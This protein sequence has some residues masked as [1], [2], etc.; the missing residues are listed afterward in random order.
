V[1]VP[2][3]KEKETQMKV[4][5]NL[6]GSRRK[7]LG[8]AQVAILAGKKAVAADKLADEDS[9]AKAATVL[10]AVHRGRAGHAEALK[11]KD[12]QTG[13]GGPLPPDLQALWDKVRGATLDDLNG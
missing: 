13:S 6:Y 4:L 12:D 8:S 1:N 3:P 7:P 9:E 11:L 2:S 10:Q 5:A